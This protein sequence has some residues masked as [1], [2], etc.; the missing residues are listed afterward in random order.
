M[1]EGMVLMRSLATPNMCHV[2]LAMLIRE[3]S[4]ISMLQKVLALL[5]I[6]CSS[7]LLGILLASMSMVGN[8]GMIS[9][10]VVEILF[11]TSLSLWLSSPMLL[12]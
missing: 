10:L 3:T 8:L 4:P 1:V 6:M 11:V 7:V 2:E 9:R 12:T 5:A